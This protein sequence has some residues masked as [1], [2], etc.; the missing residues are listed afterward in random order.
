MRLFSVVVKLVL[1]VVILCVLVRSCVL[2]L[3]SNFI[4]SD[5]LLGKCW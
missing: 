5:F 2:M 3:I 4:S 1:W